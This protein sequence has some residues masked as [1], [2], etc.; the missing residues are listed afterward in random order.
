MT[1]IQI[2]KTLLDREQ[3]LRLLYAGFNHTI[4]LH[5]SEPMSDDRQRKLS[6]IYN[7]LRAWVTQDLCAMREHLQ[8]IS[9][10]SPEYKPVNLDAV[11]NSSNNVYISPWILQREYLNQLEYLRDTVGAV[12]NGIDG[13]SPTLRN[14]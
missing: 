9:K 1:I 13:N 14:N 10:D 2:N 6:I 11:R 12:I 4:G 7:E 8:R 3:H 5:E